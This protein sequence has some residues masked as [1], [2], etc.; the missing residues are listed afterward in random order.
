LS[1]SRDIWVLGTGPFQ[2]GT[3][4]RGTEFSGEPLPV[5]VQL[6]MPRLTAKEAA[7]PPLLSVTQATAWPDRSPQAALSGLL[8][9]VA[10]TLGMLVGAMVPS[11]AAGKVRPSE[12]P[13][14]AAKAGAPAAP[15]SGGM[16]ETQP[17]QVLV[18]GVGS[19]TN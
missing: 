10:S 1:T 11:S 2:N 18:S 14:A 12:T 19:S 17:C 5:Q 4:R 6:Q 7:P 9:G 8:E 3:I 13:P 15:N 16:A